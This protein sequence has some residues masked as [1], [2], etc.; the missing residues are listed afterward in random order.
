M[1]E[2]LATSEKKIDGRTVTVCGH[3]QRQRR[4]QA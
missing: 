3:D 2:W 4:K 1:K